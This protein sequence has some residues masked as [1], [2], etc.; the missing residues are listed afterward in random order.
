MT[1]AEAGQAERAR[2]RALSDEVDAASTLLRH[3]LSILTAYRYA[4]RDADAV[5]V[6]LAGGMEK[7]LKLTIGLS[8]LDTTLSWPS[9]QVMQG[10]Y[11]HNIVGLDQE[12]RRLVYNGQQRSTA[13]GYIA[14]LLSAAAD[15]SH[16]D[17]ILRACGRYAIRGRFYNLDMLADSPQPEPSPAQ[18]WDE[19]HHELLER[20]PDLL[21]KIA[22][23]DSW[24]AGRI[25]INQLIVAAM[26]KWCEL[27][28]GAWKT[29]V[30]GQQAKVWGPQLDI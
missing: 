8:E 26:K 11:G 20:R 2:S 9:K 29:G 27:V 4:T 25:E 10:K 1:S 24:E 5:F 7:L 28:V 6:C 14:E 30:I 12:V 17:I 15:D 3:G 21:S 18:M 13:P 22:S 23:S 16:L 19:L